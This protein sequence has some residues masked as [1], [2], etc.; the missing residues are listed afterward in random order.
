MGGMQRVSMQWVEA[1]SK[2]SS[3]KLIPILLHANWKGIGLQ[4][5][6]FLLKL[7]FRLPAWVKQHRVDQIVFSSMVTASLAPLL[8]R[9]VKV[10]MVAINHGLDVTTPVKAYQWWVK[11]VFSYLTATISVSKATRQ[12][13]LE[14]GMPPERAYVI[15]NGLQA[16]NKQAHLDRSQL[17]KQV[18]ETYGLQEDRP[19]LL[20]VGRQVRRKGH[21][22]FIQEVLPRL[23]HPIQCIFVGDGPERSQI[24]TALRSCPDQHKIILTGKVDDQALQQLY[25]GADVFIM[26]N[27]PVAGDM[28]GFGIVMLEANHLGLPV[29]ATRLEGIVDVIEEGVNGITCEALQ[30][31][32]FAERLEWLLQHLDQFPPAQISDYV[33]RTF[34]W[35]AVADQYEHVLHEL[36]PQ[37]R[38]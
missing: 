36:M 1:F 22:W 25:A 38:P 21:Q 11:K 32:V 31:Q 20:S 10:P 14:R 6:F 9:R 17:R 5:A 30:P 33:H 19:L 23:K 8:S 24:E 34:S 2:R 37:N 26:P 12:A 4:T 18:I 13:C 28:E 27:I 35:D 29:L 15:P 3:V 7:W 16:S